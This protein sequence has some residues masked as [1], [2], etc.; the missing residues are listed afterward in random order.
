MVKCT[1]SIWKW[2]KTLSLKVW[3]LDHQHRLMRELVK[4]QI[5]GPL[6]RF[7]QSESM[8]HEI[9]PG[10]LHTYLKFGKHQSKTCSSHSEAYKLVNH[11]N[12]Q[13]PEECRV[14]G[15]FCIPAAQLFT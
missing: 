8:Y 3:S 6:S 5:L 11:S 4:L 15:S 13:M 1:L 12:I 2:S 10:D 9:S 7:I 14:L